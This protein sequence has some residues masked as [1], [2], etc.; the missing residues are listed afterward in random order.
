MHAQ[1]VCTITFVKSDPIAYPACTLQYNGKQCNKKVT[2]S[3]GGDGP[4]R[5]WCERCSA[6]CEAEY[7][8]MLSLNIED[9]SGKEWVTA[10][11][12]CHKASVVFHQHAPRL[13]FLFL[14]SP[15]QSC[16]LHL[17]HA[18]LPDRCLQLGR[19]RSCMLEGVA[20]HA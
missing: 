8:Y 10:F 18:G 4:N 5:W 20:Q 11:Q 19:S 3:G 16:S 6:A 2:D 1:I 13:G 17:C 9:H 15:L 7:R 14:I 12:V